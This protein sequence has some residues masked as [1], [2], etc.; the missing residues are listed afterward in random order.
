MK[1]RTL[2]RGLGEEPRTPVDGVEE[3]AA[4]RVANDPYD[5]EALR[6]LLVAAL[7]RRRVDDISAAAIRLLEAYEQ[8]GER[9]QS[10]ALIKEFLDPAAPSLPARFFLS[11]AALCDRQGRHE[12][13]YDA[14]EALV[15][16]TPTDPSSV[17]ALVRMAEIRL[18]GGNPSEARELY[19]LV[20]FHPACT[21]EVRAE[22][23]RT[24][25][26]ERF[27]SI[28]K[29]WPSRL[30]VSAEALAGGYPLAA[31]PP[32]RVGVALGAGARGVSS[33]TPPGTLRRWL[34]ATRAPLPDG[35]SWSWPAID[36][37][38][39]VGAL[40]LSVV[41]VALLVS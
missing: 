26:S 38:M 4:A 39:L 30:R 17:R 20:L 34:A 41:M 29:P 14:Y 3:R 40:I 10:S 16:R 35:H 23:Q 24:L 25:R 27:R 28:S 15:E 6:T 12:E 19:E 32:E 22:T 7:E 8:R 5:V 37:R 1:W 2:L 11:A 21:G 9:E 18:Q 31:H 13:A 36:T 33:D